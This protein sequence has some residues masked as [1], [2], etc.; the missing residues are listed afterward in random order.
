[1]FLGGGGSWNIY[2]IVHL[3]Y[4]VSYAQFIVFLDSSTSFL[5]AVFIIRY[6]F[7]DCKYLIFILLFVCIF[8]F[9]INKSVLTLR[10]FCLLF[11]S[12]FEAIE[13]MQKYNKL[14]IYVIVEPC[15]YWKGRAHRRLTLRIFFCIIITTLLIVQWKI[16]F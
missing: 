3:R 13:Y 4:C 14:A 11:L 12:L 5:N 8:F 15:S 16:L 9:W 2:I 7:F 6:W 10:L 1:M